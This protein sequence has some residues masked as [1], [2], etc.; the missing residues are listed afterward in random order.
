MNETQFRQYK[1]KFSSKGVKRQEIGLSNYCTN[2]KTSDHSLIDDKQ[3]SYTGKR[4][5]DKV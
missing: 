1:K 3:V 4:K 2:V 5:T